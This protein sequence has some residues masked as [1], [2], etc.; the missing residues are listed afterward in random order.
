MGSGGGTE[1]DREGASGSSP[2]TL[3]DSPFTLMIHILKTGSDPTTKSHL[4]PRLSARVVTVELILKD[5]LLQAALCG[6]DPAELLG[7]ASTVV[8]ARWGRVY[9]FPSQPC[10]G[11]IQPAPPLGVGVLRETLGSRAKSSYSCVWLA[12]WGGSVPLA[13]V[14]MLRPEP[15]VRVLTLQFITT[16]FGGYS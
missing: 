1:A 10:P 11:P 2:S 15:R 8:C 3:T 14:L 9:V 5:C 16:R 7:L 6:G 12:R 13:A 4:L